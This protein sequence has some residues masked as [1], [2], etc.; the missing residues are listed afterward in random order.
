MPEPLASAEL[1]L[2]P[3]LTPWYVSSS[4]SSHPSALTI[5]SFLL[6]ILYNATKKMLYP[7]SMATILL[8]QY[9]FASKAPE[10]AIQLQR[11]T[12]FKLAKSASTPED[13]EWVPV[14]SSGVDD[15]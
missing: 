1:V 5:A 14:N 9:C 6:D 4:T 12:Q 8:R 2:A 13:D 7:D 3:F 11:S 15:S 10:I